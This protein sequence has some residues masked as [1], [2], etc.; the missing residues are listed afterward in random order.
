MKRIL[1]V[2]QTTVI[3]GGSYC[4]LNILRE[5]DIKEIE[6][7]VCLPEDG[8]LS[9]ELQKLGVKVVY[10]PLMCD[11]PYNKSILSIKSL[12][13]YIKVYKSIPA[14]RRLLYNNKI[15][16]VYL[17][18]MM[19]YNYLK[20]AKEASCKTILHVRE[21][22]PLNEHINQLKWAQKAVYKYA[23]ELI[24]INNYSA[25]IFQDK[26]ATIVYDWIDMDSRYERRK[27]DELLE[28]DASKLRVYLF[29]GG[30]QP[31]KGAL[32]VLTTFVNDIKSPNARLLC[33]GFKPSIETTTVRGK[34]KKILFKLG[35]HTY[36][37]KLYK[38]VEEDRRIKCIPA[39]YMLTD[40]MQQCYCNLSYFTIPHA[41]LAMVEASLVGIPSV[42]AKNEE[43]LEY[44]L[45]GETAVLFEANNREAFREAIKE[46]SYN[47]DTYKKR[48]NVKAQEIKFM[49]NPQ[50]N[51]QL[52]NSV[53]NR[54]FF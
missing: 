9:I 38:L 14:F 45:K 40:I 28:E 2:H 20:P 36:N 46:L 4:L 35:Y 15:D 3:G 49:F 6:P 42:A 5:L 26:K 31:I 27:M 29:T 17:N 41:N 1:F 12:K 22:W 37:W 53:I 24:A 50:R 21:H 16:V 18:N 30:V 7:I 54:I 19:I 8:P 48:I 44:S 13:Q 33:L 23:D 10:F 43:S 11:I 51:I 32:E 52:L 25:S 47:Y 34:I 39:T